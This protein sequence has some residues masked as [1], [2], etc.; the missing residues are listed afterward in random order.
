MAGVSGIPLQALE[1]LAV[2]AAVDTARFVADQRP[3]HVRTAATK[4]SD[5]DVVTVMDT[6]AEQ[7]LRARLLAARPDDAVLGEEGA[8]QAGTSGLTWV[9]DPIDGTVNYLYGL[10]GY[11]V[12]VAVVTGDPTGTD[13]HPVAGAVCAPV[14]R[15]VWAA[16][17]GGGA[18]VGDLDGASRTPLEVSAQTE[19][20]HA[21]VGTGFSYRPD[22]RA[23]Q[24]RLLSRV[25]PAVR[26][27]RRMGS[28]A[29]DLCLV[30]QGRLD[31]YYER[32]LNPWDLAAGWLF[33]TEAGGVVTDASG[34]RPSR[35]GVVAGGP[36]LH[37]GL[38]HLLGRGPSAL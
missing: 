33:V 13:W 17:R 24:A 11:A 18:W 34:G 32:E 27:I 37:P 36:V 21:L 9:L 16:H 10:P 4:T 20:G 29:V 6:A 19:L 1:E 23:E 22:V 38:L 15:Q 8:D 26:D 28:A 7:R 5:T 3:A 12:S 30:A 31:L 35:E 2:S 14:L 25:L